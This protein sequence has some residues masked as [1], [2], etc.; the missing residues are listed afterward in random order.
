M[1]YAYAPGINK[2][3]GY[4]YDN[5]SYMHVASYGDTCHLKLLATSTN[6]KK[7]TIL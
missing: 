2:N 7:I 5:H 3:L 4:D 6:V 1:K